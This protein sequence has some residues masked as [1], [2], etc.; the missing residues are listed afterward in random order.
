MGGRSCLAVSFGLT[1]LHCRHRSRT[2]LNRGPP[3]F[4]TADV[5]ANPGGPLG[6]PV[7]LRWVTLPY[8]GIPRRPFEVYRRARI[9]IPAA[10]ILDADLS[11]SQVNGSSIIAFPP[12]SGGLI[13]IAAFE[14]SP[15]SGNVLVVA[16]YD[17]YGKTIPGVGLEAD[18]M[19]SSLFICP[20]MAGLRVAGFGTISVV[21]GVNQETYANLPGWERI[22]VVGL[23]TQ[24]SDHLMPAY[25]SSV[26]QGFD[27][28]LTTGILAARER[29]AL[30]HLFL[31]PPPAS[32]D[33]TFPLPAWPPSN[34]AEYLLNLRSG[35]N[36]FPMIVKC[37]QNSNDSNPTQMQSLYMETVNN[38][39]G[40][41]Q[42]NAPA[43]SN[44]TP[45][46][47]SGSAE[48]PVVSLSMLGVSTDSDAALAL[49]Y[50]TIDIPARFRL[51][52]YA[53]HTRP[54]ATNRL[55]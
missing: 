20:G 50:G 53:A 12:A 42:A 52:I 47:Q 38:L 4:A 34:P 5:N 6:L 2:G 39:D 35:R 32:G 16:P 8:L 40:I 54:A 11:G 48:I 14:A 36:L 25:N 45:A 7:D 22:Q 49:G 41:I 29:M 1:H 21:V 15:S 9:N 37:L 30:S 13:Y 26:K 23:P 51:A 10:D 18:Y 33:P 31:K 3:G 27:V 44:P 17:M 19:Q 55:Y 24:P 28:A 43:G 46:G